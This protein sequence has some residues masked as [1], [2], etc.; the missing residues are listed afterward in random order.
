MSMRIIE[1]R[2]ERAELVNQAR[3]I[4]EAAN[5]RDFTAEEQQKYDNI[6]ADVD[7]KKAHIDRLEKLEA[8]ESELSQSQGHLERPDPAQ[9]NQAKDQRSTPE[10]RAAYERFLIDGKAALSPVEI[11]AMQADS[12]TAGGYLVM[13]QQMVNELLKNVDDSVVIRQFARG[14]QL[15]QAKSLGVPTLETSFSDADW[16][17]ELRT[18]NEDDLTLGKRELRPHPLAKRAKISNTLLRLSANGAESIVRERLAYVFGATLEKAYMTGNGQGK[19]LG[20]FTASADGIT[21]ARDVSAGNTATEVSGDGLINALMSLKEAHQAKARWIFH[22]D[23]ISQIRKLKDLNGVYLWQPGITGGAP[24]RILEKAYSMSE[25]APNTL[26]TGQ[27]V[28]LVGNLEYYWYADALDMQIQRL[29]ELYA[30]TNQTGFIGRYE[31]DGMP[32]LAE[33]FA[34]VKL[35]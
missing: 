6:M 4:N 15:K 32:V 20:L 26:T 30:E 34:R 8:Q 13:P 22:R 10:Y 27:Y 24:D 16:T 28:G 21:T 29:V 11:K 31:G 25:F 12:D 33:A 19:P 17:T 9:A 1:M 7:K 23:V 18:G 14:F 35:A 5:G 3:A 2:Q